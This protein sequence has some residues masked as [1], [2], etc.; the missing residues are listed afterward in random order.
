MRQGLYEQIINNITAKQVSALDPERYEIGR[1]PLDAEEARKMLSNYLAMVTRKALKV[2][3]EQS[4]DE[5]AV[6]VQFRTLVT[7]Y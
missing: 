1:E 6:F 3:R 2:V 4:S 5:E 7:G